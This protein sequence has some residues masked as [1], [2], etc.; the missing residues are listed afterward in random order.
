[1]GRVLRD[2]IAE[3][4]CLKLIREYWVV[5]NEIFLSCASGGNFPSLSPFDFTT[6]AKTATL[7]D[8]KVTMAVIDMYFVAV[9]VE[10]GEE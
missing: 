10:L 4:G 2:D 9:N 7:P 8:K 6:F 3:E 1:M 5:L